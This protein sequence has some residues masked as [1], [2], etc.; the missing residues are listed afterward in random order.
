MLFLHVH[1]R[2]VPMQNIYR[3]VTAILTKS[4]LVIARFNVCGFES[5]IWHKTATAFNVK[6]L[7]EAAKSRFRIPP[8]PEG[9]GIQ[10]GN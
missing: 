7:R 9:R 10:R 6:S 1:R 3:S 8:C 4:C 5:F 2:R